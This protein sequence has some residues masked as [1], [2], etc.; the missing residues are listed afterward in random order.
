M[1]RALYETQVFPAMLPHQRAFIV[2]GTF[3]CEGDLKPQATQIS[4][5]LRLYFEW[6]KQEPRIAGIVP[7]HFANRS[8]DASTK[9]GSNTGPGRRRRLQWNESQHFG[10]SATRLPACPNGSFRCK[11]SEFCVS[12]SCSACRSLCKQVGQRPGHC[13][14][15][16]LIGAEAMPEVVSTLAFIGKQIVGSTVGC[17]HDFKPNQ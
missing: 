5:K 13:S 9:V 14:S 10:V 11:C 8:A 16:S 17:A 1:V 4:T 6:A 2:P 7:W 15:L 12:N 3:G